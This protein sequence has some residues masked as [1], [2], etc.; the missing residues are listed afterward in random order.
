MRQ[1]HVSF[2]GK[3]TVPL[4]VAG[5]VLAVAGLTVANS[6]AEQKSLST[7][8]MGESMKTRPMAG[9]NIA[10]LKDGNSKLKIERAVA[11]PG[12]NAAKTA[13][14]TF[15]LASVDGQAITQTFDGK[16][17]HA[18]GSGG[19]LK[20]GD[21]KLANGGAI[22]VRGGIIVWDAFGVVA[23][24]KRTGIASDLDPTG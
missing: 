10:P 16:S 23:K 13:F 7:L 24:L 8:P 14:P 9:Q 1:A 17:F 6:R 15:A 3:F 11:N 19:P 21:Y 5:A 2:V 20:D 12:G 18:R 4:A 22:K